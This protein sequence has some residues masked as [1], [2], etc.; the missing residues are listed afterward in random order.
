[1]S[2]P[3]VI[4]LRGV[5]AGYDGRT[6][7]DGVD[8]TVHRGEFVALVG[9]NGAGKST[10]LKAIVGLLRPYEGSVRVFGAAP[11]TSSRHLAYLPQAE[12]VHWDYP[13]RVEDVVLM[14][15][16]AH[17][18]AS[19]GPSLAD[20]SAVATAMGRVQI[21]DLARRPIKALSGG[22]RQRVLLARTLAAEPELLLLDEPATGV[23]PATEEQL[24][25]LLGDLASHG[26]T[27]LV[28]THDLAGVM[29]HFPRVLCMNGGIVADGDASILR[30]DAI[31][32]RTYGGHRPGGPQHI[33][34]EHHA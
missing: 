1:V 3:A 23:D 16:V 21:G 8:L 15:R 5:R 14:G 12:Q 4:E 26:R 31:L 9:A 10:L 20:R 17:S 24:M 30:D 7:I 11:G 33:A 29:A 18:T 6:V 28:A 34:D 32:R 19:R 25:S 2:D 27:V 13:L 22:Q